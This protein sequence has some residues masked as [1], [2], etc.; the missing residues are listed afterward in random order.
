MA[1]ATKEELKDMIVRVLAECSP[2]TSTELVRKVSEAFKDK[3]IDTRLLRRVVAS[4]VKEGVVRR[5]V[6][7]EGRKI[8]FSL[9]N[10][11]V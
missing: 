8:L 2:C 11:K 6:D 7:Y 9:G 1:Y 5:Y 10:L 4:L 3:K